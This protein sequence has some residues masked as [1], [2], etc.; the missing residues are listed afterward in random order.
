M[1]KIKMDSDTINLESKNIKIDGKP[2]DDYILDML[3]RK[4][5]ERI[6]KHESMMKLLLM[7]GIQRLN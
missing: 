2:L 6:A 7:P 3:R 1:E 4:A 5:E